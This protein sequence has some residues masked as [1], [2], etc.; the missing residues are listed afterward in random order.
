MGLTHWASK[1]GM[2]FETRVMGLNK[3]TWVNDD[4]AR[5]DGYENGSVSRKRATFEATLRKHT[6]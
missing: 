1:Q 6:T 5:G 2:G 3:M 4:P